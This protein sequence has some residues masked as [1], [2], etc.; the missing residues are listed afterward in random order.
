MFDIEKIADTIVTKFTKKPSIKKL[1]KSD[2]N[3]EYHDLEGAFKLSW[4]YPKESRDSGGD[5]T[6][7]TYV[8]M[9]LSSEFVCV[10]ISSY[11]VD[12]PDDVLAF[13][14]KYFDTQDKLEKFIDGDLP[15]W[16]D[17]K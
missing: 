14:S 11:P 10:S 3:P 16:V 17:E 5:F 4:C 6:L 1:G 8:E 15:Y 7:E 13:C 9:T 12:T 2:L